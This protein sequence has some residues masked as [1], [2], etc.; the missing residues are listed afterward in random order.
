MNLKEL[1]KVL[2]EKGIPNEIYTFKYEYI[3]DGFCIN[4]N[5]QKWET[6]YSE[7]GLKIGIKTFDTEEEACEYLY[8]EILAYGNKILEFR[9]KRNEL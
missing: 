9:K 3:N 5:G 6:Y 8:P 1:K 4:F 7:R 2:D